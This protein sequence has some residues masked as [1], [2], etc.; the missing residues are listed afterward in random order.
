MSPSP[1]PD[2]QELDPQLR[3]L[4]G[5]AAPPTIADDG[6]T[7]RCM[8]RLQQHRRWRLLGRSA[9]AAAI[10]I[11]VGVGLDRSHALAWLVDAVALL[12]LAAAR[13]TAPLGAWLITPAGWMVSLLVG[14]GALWRLK[15]GRR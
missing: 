11:G 9:G 6:F 4:F 13:E 5:R 14:T 8:Q 3:A 10:A 2:S 12:P 15:A 7:Q 1:Q